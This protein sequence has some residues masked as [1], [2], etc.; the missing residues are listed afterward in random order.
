MLADPEA[1]TRGVL[2]KKVFLEIPQNLQEK[3]SARISFL[4]NLQAWGLQ[5]YYKSDSGTEAFLLILR[6]F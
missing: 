2:W 3:T 5:L 4:I 6:N 1:A